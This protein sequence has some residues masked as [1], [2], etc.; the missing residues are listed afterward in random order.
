MS[1][2]SEWLES[3][4]NRRCNWFVVIL[5]LVFVGCN[6]FHAKRTP[7]WFDELGT[8]YIARVP[9][10]EQIW[11]AL[12][13]PADG[14][15]PLGFWISRV[16]CQALGWTP[17]ALRLP[18]MLGYLVMML[19]IFFIVRRYTTPVYALIAVLASYLT[20]VP[21]FAIEARPYGL[22][23]GLSSLALLSW[24]RA[25]E[26]RNR[27]GSLAVL[28]LSLS[29][30]FFCH[31]YAVLTFF[32]LAAGEAARVWMRKRIDW[33]V[34]AV[35]ALA[36]ASA[37]LLLPLIR[38]SATFRQTGF[39][40]PTLQSFATAMTDLVFPLNGI[41]IISLAALLMAL[42]RLARDGQGGPA[43]TALV[44]PTH[45]LVAWTALLLAPVEAVVV[46]KLVSGVLVARYFIVFVIGFSILLAVWLYRTF[47]G[48]ASAGL[49]ILCLC[50]FWFAVRTAVGSRR[51]NSAGQLSRL[52]Q[53][54]NPA[55][56]PVAVADGVQFFELAY[57]A[58]E[59]VRS[60]LV[61][62][63]DPPA[64]LRYTRSS[65]VDTNLKGF[66]AFAPIN[67]PDYS[68]FVHSHKSFLMLWSE[69]AWLPLKLNADGARI[70]FKGKAGADALYSVEY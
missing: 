28:C 62:L 32:G 33:P 58:P 12:A 41:L 51:E 66:R 14:C 53:E 47:C 43:D 1:R 4:I 63:T 31:Y 57:Y 67:V 45:E 29:A 48:S 5:A 8:L 16:S 21:A 52:V 36:T 9:G 64:A 2:F 23:L 54:N 17:A 15:P 18:E 39:A 3:A 38:A 37:F 59:D 10:F 69:N 56:L 22:L 60:N 27:F 65:M 20:R 35:F 25:T 19:C 49:A 55:H 42:L 50:L 13:V 24:M 44:P 70:V 68:E 61:Y 40:P 26:R 46:G 34:F 30:T 11:K 7:L 6:W